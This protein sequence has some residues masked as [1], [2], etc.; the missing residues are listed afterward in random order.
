M[1]AKVMGCRTIEDCPPLAGVEGGNSCQK[2]FLSFMPFQ[3]AYSPHPTSMGSTGKSTEILSDSC[4]SIEKGMQK[5][6]ILY[7]QDW[8]RINR[9]KKR[10][11][12]NIT[13]INQNGDKMVG[14]IMNN[15]KSN[16]DFYFCMMKGQTI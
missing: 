5:S 4:Q 15:K 3:K 1:T 2:I 12:S 6:V 11:P 8:W 16:S 13:G 10:H 7:A 9:I 14:S